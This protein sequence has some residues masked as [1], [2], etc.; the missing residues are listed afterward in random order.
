MNSK[1]ILI[2]FAILTVL[3]GAQCKKDI[4]V[5][6]ELIGMWETTY[7]GFDIRPFEIRKGTLIFEQG[8]GYFDFVTYPIVGVIQ[9]FEEGKILYVIS[10]VIPDGL[11]YKF[12]FYYNPA[13][14]GEIRFKN[15]SQIKWTKR[16][17]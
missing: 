4:T 17:T 7:P 14:G 1:T 6:D 16:R 2:A 5:P 13:K 10:Y 15:R 12:S 9:T 11:I 3:F 8:L